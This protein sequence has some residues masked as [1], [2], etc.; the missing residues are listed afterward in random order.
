METGVRF[1]ATA[2]TILAN[3]CIYSIICPGGSDLANVDFNF[4]PFIT[5]TNGSF[6]RFLTSTSLHLDSKITSRQTG[7]YLI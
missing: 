7:C 6:A 2:N 4:V 5:S 1:A 3:Q